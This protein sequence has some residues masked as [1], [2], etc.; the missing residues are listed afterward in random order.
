MKN[1]SAAEA[2]V[3]KTYTKPTIELG[4]VLNK[5]I[6]RSGGFLLSSLSEY[7]GNAREKQQSINHEAKVP[8]LNAIVKPL[9]QEDPCR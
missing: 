6:Q 5:G 1:H 4:F 7:E 9:A 3:A 2:A 8:L